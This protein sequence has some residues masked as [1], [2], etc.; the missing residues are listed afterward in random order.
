MW[1]LK[2]ILICLSI[3]K[4]QKHLRDHLFYGL[5]KQLHNFIHFLYDDPGVV[6][7][8]L[9]VVAHKTES[10]QED[11]PGEEVQVRSVQLEGKDDIM[12]LKE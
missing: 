11:R 3:E 10:E 2:N 5:H 8:Q 7:P 9:E 6:Y 1:F 12:S 4:V